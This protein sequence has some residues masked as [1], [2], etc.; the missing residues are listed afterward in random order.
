MMPFARFQIEGESMLPA[1]KNGDRVLVWRWGS[2]REG[3]TVVFCKAG[4]TMVKRVAKKNG[5]RLHLRGD[6]VSASTDSLDFGEVGVKEVVGR[7]VIRY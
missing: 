4:M 7:V 2:V 6:N 5:D 1:F 3:D